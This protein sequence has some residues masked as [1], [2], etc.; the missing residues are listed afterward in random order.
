MTTMKDRVR[1]ALNAHNDC[2]RD[3][4]GFTDELVDA[5][6]AA[7]LRTPQDPPKR[8]HAYPRCT[9]TAT[10]YQALGHPG[11]CDGRDEDD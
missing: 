10:C 9:Y 5:V 1:A 3:C 4:G 6:I 2:G 7:V 11:F 8:D